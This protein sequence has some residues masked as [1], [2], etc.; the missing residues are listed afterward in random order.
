[1][2]NN[3]LATKADLHALRDEMKTD[4]RTLRDELMEAMRDTETRLLK[5]FYNFAESNQMRLSKVERDPGH[6]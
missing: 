6:D 1:M 4:L 2:A 3:D 5:A